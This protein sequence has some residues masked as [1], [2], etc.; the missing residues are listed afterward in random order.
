VRIS[1]LAFGPIL[2]TY[3]QACFCILSLLKESSHPQ[4]SVTT[5]NPDFFNYLS[6]RIQ[7]I[8]LNQ[9][10]LESWKGSA[11][12]F[13]RIKIK[14]IED[15][16]LRF[17]GEHVVFLDTDTFLANGLH[18]LNAK[19]DDGLPVMHEREG[20]LCEIGQKRYEEM[21]TVFKD[22]TFC[23]IQINSA[24]EIWNA[25]VV[26]IPGQQSLQTIQ[27]ALNLCDKLCAIDVR[28]AYLEQFALSLALN[29]ICG[30]II[31]ANQW[32]GHYWGNK[33]QWNETIV[34]FFLK[35]FL[36]KRTLEQDLT[37]MK[38]FDYSA[39]PI[40]M[41]RQKKWVTKLRRL[42]TKNFPLKAQGY[43]PS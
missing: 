35:S 22:K 43:H 14:A 6:D 12:F 41:T 27:L 24:T 42:L 40:R 28:R 13:W 8:S 38:S 34:S 1:F 23:G 7:I 36:E 33:S 32:I 10:K 30:P 31:P 2:T 4:I 15:A 19:L 39:L 20:R 3:Y 17:P 21:W 18:E 37:V 26:G 29:K 9:Q 11:N 16:I 5:D 25:G